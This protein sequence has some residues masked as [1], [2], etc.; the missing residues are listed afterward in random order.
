MG[1]PALIGT[2]DDAGYRWDGADLLLR[3]RAQP[4]ARRDEWLGLAD[5]QFRIRLATPPVD[6]RANSHL[7]EFLAGL[8][9]VA[10]S[11]VTLVAGETGR[12]KWLR[13]VAPQRLPPGIAPRASFPVVA[14]SGAD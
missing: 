8:C 12:D 13:I 2:P 9:G 7:R 14:Q 5:G 10:K 11:R 6:G 4:R 3:I 1:G